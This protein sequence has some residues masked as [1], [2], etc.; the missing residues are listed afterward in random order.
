MPLSISESVRS[1]YDH[2]GFM[3]EGSRLDDT[4]SM[5]EHFISSL[6][7]ATEKNKAA[8]RCISRISAVNYTEPESAFISTSEKVGF[9]N[10]SISLNL[11]QLLALTFLAIHDA[12]KRVG[13][14]EQAKAKFVDG[15]YKIQRE[16]NFSHTGEDRAGEDKPCGPEGTFNKLV[17]ILEGIHPDIVY[18]KSNFIPEYAEAAREPL[19]RYM[20]P[21]LPKL[22][23]GILSQTCR[24]FH[25]LTLFNKL[26]RAAASGEQKDINVVVAMIKV[27]PGLL[28]ERGDVVTRGGTKIINTTVYEFFL[29]SGHTEA[30]L[31]M[32]DAN[33]FA[34]LPGDGE[35]ER[36]HQYDRYRPHIEQLRE[37]VQAYAQAYQ[38]AGNAYESTYEP[39]REYN[40][41]YHLIKPLIEFI[42]AS[43]QADVTAELNQTEGHESE[44]R[45]KMCEFRETINES[46]REITEG[47]HYAHYTTIMLVLHLLVEKWAVLSHN[48]SN[49]DKCRL[50]ISQI[51]GYLELVG[52]PARERFA[53][54]RDFDDKELSAACRYGPNRRVQDFD[55]SNLVRT[56]LGF[57][58]GIIGDLRDRH[59]GSL[60]FVAARFKSHVEQKLDALGAYAH[61]AAD[62][63]MRT[64]LR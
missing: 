18:I 49:Y 29:G 47:M 22:N 44:L 21:F 15:L 53:F 16:Y 17:E 14:L 25:K 57:S 3:I 7:E 27:H 61:A 8:K 30:L 24:F 28:L 35:A 20:L 40:P 46:Q 10:K 5:I 43:S 45:N 64:S 37:D 33:L 32:R 1:L 59:G 4:L 26:I 42:I 56:G 62:R 58:F 13:D 41:S 63:N 11:K 31:A 6:P 60:F 36:M 54:A 9:I 34:L 52:L 50:V 48:Y 55:F 39:D 19:Q 12:G 23:L 51:F 38:Q 2:Y